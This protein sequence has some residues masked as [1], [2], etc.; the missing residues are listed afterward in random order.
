[1]LL[2]LICKPR[3]SC[4]ASRPKQSNPICSKRFIRFEATSP[5]T[6]RQ[7]AGLKYG[8]HAGTHRTALTGFDNMHS[9]QGVTQKGE[10]AKPGR[11][12]QITSRG[13]INN[14]RF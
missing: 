14:L 5:D 9:G 10:A 8:A 7:G 6:V 11:I 13:K 12:P 2:N 1:M 4:A 3:P